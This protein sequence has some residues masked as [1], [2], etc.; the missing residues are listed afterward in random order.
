M[1]AGKPSQ[2]AEQPE[3]IIISFD[4]VPRLRFPAYFP[5]KE[6]CHC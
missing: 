5:E 1:E 3:S 6:C 4:A 2:D